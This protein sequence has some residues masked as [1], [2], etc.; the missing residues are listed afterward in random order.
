MRIRRAV[1]LILAGAAALGALLPAG[2]QAADPD[3]EF[4][5]GDILYQRCASAPAD[6]DYAANHAACR[7]YVLGVSDALQAAQGAGRGAPPPICLGEAAADKVVEQVTT[8]LSGHPE[9]RRYAAPDL[10]A[11]ALRAAYPLACAAP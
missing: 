2:A 10:V 8:Y 6:L 4:F 11:A 7:A 9:N 5:T 3:R 1:R